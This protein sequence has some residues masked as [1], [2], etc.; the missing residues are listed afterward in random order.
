[1]AFCSMLFNAQVGVNELEPK[2]NLH[3][4]AET[5]ASPESYVGFG[6]PVI[7]AFPA[8]NPTADQNGMLVY[9]SNTSDTYIEG[10]YYWDAPRNAW[11]Y[12]VDY[13]T[14]QISIFK[15]IATGGSF[16]N[17]ITTVNVPSQ[18]P[19]TKLTT[20]FSSNVLTS[21]GGLKMSKAGQYFISFSGGVGKTSASSISNFLAEILVNGTSVLTSSN[22][23]PSYGDATL[24]EDRYCSFYNSGIVTLNTGDVLTIQVTRKDIGSGINYVDSPFTLT[25]VYID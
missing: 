2:A 10:Y 21:A 15:T 7:T 3:M 1:M 24:A 11:E 4:E 8:T 16:K 19:L 23:S 17:N 5:P 13:R 9:F 22:N 20:A 18:V 12:L 14:Q 25:L 6:V